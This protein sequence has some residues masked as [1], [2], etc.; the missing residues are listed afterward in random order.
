[1]DS[2]DDDID[3]ADSMNPF[4]LFKNK[5]YSKDNNEGQLDLCTEYV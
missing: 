2:S 3:D 5:E 1:M 4:K